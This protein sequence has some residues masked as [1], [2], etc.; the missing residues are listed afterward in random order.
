[1]YRRWRHIDNVN[2]LTSHDSSLSTQ[3]AQNTDLKLAI[4]ILKP[5][6]AYVCGKAAVVSTPEWLGSLMLKLFVDIAH[7]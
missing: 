4:T 7:N 1:M 3:C 2:I 6:W 5:N